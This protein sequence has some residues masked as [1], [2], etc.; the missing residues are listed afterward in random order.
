MVLTRFSLSPTTSSFSSS[1][2]TPQHFSS[3]IHS[4]Y[5]TQRQEFLT[6]IPAITKRT[7]NHPFLN[8]GRNSFLSP[9]RPSSPHRLLRC[10]G[11]AGPF[12]RHNHPHITLPIPSHSTAAP[13]HQLPQL[14]SRPPVSAASDA[15]LN[16]HFSFGCHCH[17]LKS[18]PRYDLRT[19][20]SPTPS[21][22]IPLCQA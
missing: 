6:G 10:R 11:G 8:P 2:H 20:S 4:L 14:A 18:F 13:N 7:R 17:P 9:A 22:G 1:P 5:H 19:S 21:A 3:S 16:T 15:P 12:H